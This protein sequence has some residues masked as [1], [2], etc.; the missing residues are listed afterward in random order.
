[1]PIHAFP[2]TRFDKFSNIG[3][4]IH[5]LHGLNRSFATDSH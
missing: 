4:S 3:V 5:H 2:H 1:M